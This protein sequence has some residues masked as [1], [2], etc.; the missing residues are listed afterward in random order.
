M[1]VLLSL[2][3]LWAQAAHAIEPTSLNA[4]K[5][6]AVKQKPGDPYRTLFYVQRG[7][8]VWL[9]EEQGEWTRV[10]SKNRGKWV[11]GYI[12]TVD[13]N[14]APEPEPPRRRTFAVG[15]G[16]TYSNLSQN[17][18]SFET[19][20]EVKYTL[21]SYSSASAWPFIV[22]QSRQEDFWRV[23]LGYRI[24]NF[25]GTA[26]TDVGG[27]YQKV[28]VGQRMVSLAVERAWNLPRWK[29]FYAGAGGEADKG[30]DITVRLAGSDLPTSSS[31]LQSYFGVVG[32]AG[33]Q[34]HLLDEFSIFAEG[35]IA[36]F[37]SQ[38]APVYGYEA[39]VAGLYW[40]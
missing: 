23:R 16:L 39:A 36:V 27:T 11:T 6:L 33:W 18:K 21:S 40:F 35:R 17:G 29:S 10:K 28:E 15:L 4:P 3:F 34:T 38:A 22:A 2:W 9:Y 14:S 31:D 12:L 32:I 1:H 20:D 7:E 37:L 5:A 26:H 19:D 24:A 25:K 13:L 8:K 30:I